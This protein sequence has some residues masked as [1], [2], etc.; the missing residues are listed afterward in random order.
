MKDFG[1]VDC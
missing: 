1:L